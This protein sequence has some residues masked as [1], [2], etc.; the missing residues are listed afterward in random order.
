MDK[1]ASDQLTQYMPELG[2]QLSRGL[3]CHL[4]RS[5]DTSVQCSAA[6][7]WQSMRRGPAERRVPRGA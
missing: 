2:K 4:K 6:L 7:V 3:Q 5:L 1:R